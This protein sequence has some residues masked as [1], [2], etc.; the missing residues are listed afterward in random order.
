MLP[1]VRFPIPPVR[2]PAPWKGSEANAERFGDAMG[3]PTFGRPLIRLSGR[4]GAFR[5]TVHTLDDIAGY[6]TM[7]STVAGI[8]VVPFQTEMVAGTR[9]VPFQ[10]ETSRPLGVVPR[11]AQ[12]DE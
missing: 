3:T 12:V 6:G 5:N 2:Q 11:T 8:S 9:D 1:V 4:L 10:T 7:L